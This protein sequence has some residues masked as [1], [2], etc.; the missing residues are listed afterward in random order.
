MFGL[1]GGEGGLGFDKKTI[2]RLQGSSFLGL[3]YRILNI[4]H[5]KELLWSLWVDLCL[6][7]GLPQHPSEARAGGTQRT[8]YPLLKEY[9][10]KL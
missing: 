4:N 8:Q 1:A 10:L 3:P 2:H 9:A 6:C 5:K 7:S